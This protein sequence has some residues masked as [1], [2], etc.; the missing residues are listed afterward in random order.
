LSKQ[1]NNYE[2]YVFSLGN[3]DFVF[4]SDIASFSGNTNADS[5]IHSH[6]FCELFYIL[7]GEMELSAEKN[8][9]F[10]KGDCVII[11]RD[12]M[13]ASKISDRSKRLVLSFGVSKNSRSKKDY[14][15][16]FE[17]LIKNNVTFFE[18]FTG[19]DAFRRVASYYCS[20]YSDKNAL[21]TA[22]LQEI[23]LLIKASASSEIP[24]EASA[25]T[26]TDS[27]RNYIIEH[28]FGRNYQNGTLGELADILHLSKQQTGRII[29]KL[30]GKTFNEKIL[31]ERMYLAH[32]LLA[33]TKLDIGSIAA[34]LGYKS[35]SSFYEAFK[36]F[37][38]TTPF[39]FR[40][41]G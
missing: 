27:Y 15:S 16:A 38:G 3:T 18:N 1:Y 29:S 35:N 20:C 33:D 10:A 19:G 40:K 13:H 12:V 37:H 30:Y 24:T 22:C 6:K 9:L 39:K 4:I 2:E 14:F 11:P 5:P 36:K 7:D 17:V 8:Y 34:E 21:I 25:H 28:Y 23:M 31:E 26:D 41:E 32:K